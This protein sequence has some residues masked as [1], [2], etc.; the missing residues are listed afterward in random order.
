MVQPLV[1]QL[2]VRWSA[3]ASLRYSVSWL[4]CNCGGGGGAP[5]HVRW[6]N[7]IRFRCGALLC[8]Y[9]D[10]DEWSGCESAWC[11]DGTGREAS[12]ALLRAPER[13]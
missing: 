6:S 10:G 7:P 2:L 1:A 5:T 9:C 3:K 13:L 12:C 4:W 8:R 11:T